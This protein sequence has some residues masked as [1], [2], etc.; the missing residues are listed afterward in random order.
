MLKGMTNDNDNHNTT[1]DLFR[2]HLDL[3]PN[4]NAFYTNTEFDDTQ[5]K[6][7]SF[8]KVSIMV[9][10]LGGQTETQP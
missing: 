8:P 5:I 10:K 4:G 3:I 9:I 1:Q 7:W 6:L 2:T